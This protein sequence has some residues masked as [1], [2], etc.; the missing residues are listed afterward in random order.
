MGGSVQAA[1]TLHVK[2]GQTHQWGASDNLVI[3]KEMILE[4]NAA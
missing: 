4:D 3:L 2:Q 1:E